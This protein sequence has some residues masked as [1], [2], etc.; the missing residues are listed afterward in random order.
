MSR[1]KNERKEHLSHDLRRKVSSE[2]PDLTRV[3]LSTTRSDACKRARLLACHTYRH[4][5][6]ELLQ[7]IPELKV[8]RKRGG[9]GSGVALRTGLAATTCPLIACAPCDPAYRPQ[10]L[11]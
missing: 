8:L 2:L 1:W 7:V 10:D 5:A 9:Q 4:R 3:E 6:E 11:E